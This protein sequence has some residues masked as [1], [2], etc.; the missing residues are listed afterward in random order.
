MPDSEQQNKN[1]RFDIA[2]SVLQL[3]LVVLFIGSAVFTAK[4]LSDSRQQTKQIEN[5][6]SDVVVAVQTIQP[7]PYQMI[8]QTTGEVQARNTVE[9]IPEVSGRV[10]W[11]ESNF[12]TGGS[13][14]AD[15]PLFKIDDE[16]FIYEVDR[17]KADV[18]EKRTS[19]QLAH[20][21]AKASL[22]EWE[23]LYPNEEPPAL[24]V[25]RPQ[26]EQ[27]RAA[28]NASNAALK[29]AELDLLRTDFELPFNG[30]ILESSIDVGQFVQQGQGYGS[31]Y[32]NNTL[33]VK[34]SLRDDEVR[35]IAARE[36]VPV[37]LIADFK[38]KKHQFEGVVA[39]IGSKLND[40]TRFNEVI[41]Q[42]T[43]GAED[44]VPGLLVDVRIMGPELESVWEI[45]NDAMQEAGVVWEVG[46]TQKLVK[47][48]PEVIYRERKHYIIEAENRP[49]RIVRGRALNVSDGMSVKIVEE[50]AGV[51]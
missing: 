50:E 28:L 5:K 51:E 33:E 20:A 18:S 16:D 43:K 17:L 21:D 37:I 12:F 10:V 44:V 19:F 39:R 13:F 40:T 30:R 36:N 6:K 9:I 25:K 7:K 34:A 32:A 15:A 1:S 41:I 2:K 45:P 22:E 49:L 42:V 4:W 3:I 23:T 35:W 48:V 27:A 8:I 26:L 29:Q 11:V 38:G 47:H 24:V 14:L 46:L 31:V